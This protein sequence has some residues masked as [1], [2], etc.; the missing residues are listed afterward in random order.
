M[1]KALILGGGGAVGNAWETAIIT[2]LIKN[3]VPLAEAEII[4]GTSAGSIVGSKLACGVELL[5]K[6]HSKTF[7]YPQ[8]GPDIESIKAVFKLWTSV[9]FM[10]DKTSKQI[11]RIASKANTIS[12]QEWTSLVAH[13]MIDAWPEKDLRICSVNANTGLFE[14]FT[15][16]DGVSLRK[17]IASSCAIP[18][19][20]PLITLEQSQYMDGGVYS[21]TNAQIVIED[22]PDLAVIIA[23]ICKG[24]ALIGEFADRCL[25][26]EV[27]QL[28]AKGCKVMVISPN[29]NDINALGD[30]LMDTSRLMSASMA[31]Q[32]RALALLNEMKIA[33]L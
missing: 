5:G 12:E 27:Q 13:Q 29:E 25:Q 11:A 16:D 15:K 23:P 9:E 8:S 22:Q 14:V 1:N 33:W 2:T 24:T 26:S 28:K 20:F 4:V 31:G 30:N 19:M 6:D 7:P 17:V 21:G 18:G 3:D 10:D 32:K